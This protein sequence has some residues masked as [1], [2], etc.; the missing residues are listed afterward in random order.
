MHNCVTSLFFGEKIE[1]IRGDLLQQKALAARPVG[2]MAP[3]KGAPPSLRK[4]YASLMRPA[5]VGANPQAR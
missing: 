4:L 2:H 3:A 5:S 1:E